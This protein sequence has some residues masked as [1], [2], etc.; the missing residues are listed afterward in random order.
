MCIRDRT[1]TLP[2]WDRLA[3]A[4]CNPDQPTADGAPQRPSPS[5]L[6]ANE[7]RRAPDSVLMA[8]QV[9]QQ[10][11]V[12]SGHDAAGLASVFTSAHGDLPI[13]DALCRTLA[14][15]PLAL[16]LSL[17]HISTGKAWIP[18]YFG[19]DRYRYE[20]VYKGQGR[21]LFASGAG[22]GWDANTHLIWICLLYTSRCV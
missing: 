15:N 12:A 13:T 22:F 19:S 8:L 9:A 20:V 4:L 7:R 18:F 2:D 1:P 11:V 5:L 14:D 6:A 17:I 16:S 10:A 21:L 3:L